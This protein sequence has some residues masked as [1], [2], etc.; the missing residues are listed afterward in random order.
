[1]GHEA[2]NPIVRALLVAEEPGPVQRVKTGS[3]K[4][5]RVADVMEYRGCFQQ[6]RIGAEDRTQGAGALGD[7]ERVHPAARQRIRQQRF[8]ERVRPRSQSHDGQGYGRPV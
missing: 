6:L 2:D 4:A 7:P 5:R 1:M 8:G 3:G